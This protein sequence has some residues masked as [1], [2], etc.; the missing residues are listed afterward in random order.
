MSAD[1]FSAASAFSLIEMLVVMAMVALLGAMALPSWRAQQNQAVVDEAKLVL[2]RLDLR[3]RT[4]LLRYARPATEAELPALHELSETVAAHY[5]LEVLIRD[6]G[7]RQ[8]LVP[9]KPDLPVIG[10][11]DTGVWVEAV[12]PEPEH[13]N[14]I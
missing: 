2:Q 12:A 6:T 1:R 5:R 14:A 9:T 7:Y 8:R 10:L 11:G 3:Q 4:Y 13:G